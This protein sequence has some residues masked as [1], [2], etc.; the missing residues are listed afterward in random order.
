MAGTWELIFQIKWPDILDIFIVAFVIYWI[1]LLIRGTRSVQMLLGLAF[2]IVA[3]LIAQ[4][5]GLV[6]IH[7]ILRNFIDSI[8][9]II[10]VIFQNDI[11][12]ALSTMGKNPFFS[13]S[14]V[15]YKPSLLEEVA[16]ASSILARNRH[17]ALIVLERVADVKEHV[18]VGVELD[19]TVTRDLLLSIFN[20]SSPLH[21]GAVLI[22][23]GR[24][25]AARC[26]LPLSQNPRVSRFIGTRHRAALGLTEET[27]AVVVVVSEERGSISLA[28]GGRLTRDLDAGGLRRVL[29]N[30]LAPPKKERRWWIS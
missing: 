3:F 10:I 6:T 16:E 5:W 7:W 20:P 9:I 14:P 13:V 1:L 11:R 23:G 22:Q 17:G 8:I 12:R 19:A 24:V 26:F 29:G 30:L 21:D 28:L 25:S 27:D 15:S 2:V 4:R 18:E